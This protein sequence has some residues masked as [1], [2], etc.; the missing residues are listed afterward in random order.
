MYN[1]NWNNINEKRDRKRKSIFT[2]KTEKLIIKSG[3]KE[4]PYNV[5]LEALKEYSL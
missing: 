2:Q 5:I 1:K 4:N 3:V